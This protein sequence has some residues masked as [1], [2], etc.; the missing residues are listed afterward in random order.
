VI[1]TDAVPLHVEVGG[2]SQIPLLQFIKLIL[3]GMS[4]CHAPPS[5]ILLN[6]FP[7]ELNH[8]NVVCPT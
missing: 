1:L 3:P 7:V 8:C 4:L 6:V 5:G 2:V